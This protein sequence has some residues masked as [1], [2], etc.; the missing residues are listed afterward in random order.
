MLGRLP[1]FRAFCFLNTLRKVIRKPV[2]DKFVAQLWIDEDVK[3]AI[4]AGKQHK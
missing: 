3:I 4:K 2:Q 1:L